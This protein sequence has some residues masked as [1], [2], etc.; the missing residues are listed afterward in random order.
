LKGSE[1]MSDRL[2]RTGEIAKRWNLSTDFIRNR[3]ND[4]T[5]AYHQ[6]PGRE[7]RST[8]SQVEAYIESVRVEVNPNQIYTGS[9]SS[10]V[11]EC[12][13]KVTRE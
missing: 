11:S 2:L 6:L 12:L 1:D 5:L 3:W 4:G 9:F 8:E 10:L 13:A 7:R